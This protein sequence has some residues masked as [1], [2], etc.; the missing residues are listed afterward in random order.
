MRRLVTICLLALSATALLVGMPAASSAGAKK[1]S[2]PSITRVTPMRV[3]VGNLLT[4]RGRHFKAKRTANTVIFRASSGRTAFAKPRRASTRKLVVV[5]PAAVSRLLKV[6]GS[7]QRPTR[8]KLR[9][10]AGRFS[11]Y[12]PRRLS[13]VVTGFGDGDG[14]G[15]VG[16]GRSVG[17]GGGG[18]GVANSCAN[19][20]D[21]DDDLLENGLEAQIGTDPC[22]PDTD[23]DQ[24]TDGWEYWAAKDLNIKALPYPGERPFPNALDPSDG[25]APG[26][27]FSMIDFDGDGLTTL[28]EYRAWRSTGSSFDGAAAAPSSALG[29]SDGTKLS[30]PNDAPAAPALFDDPE[31]RDS[32]R[33]A[34]G[35]GLANW[36]ESAGGPSTN[37]WWKGWFGSKHFQPTVEPWKNKEYCGYRFGHFDQRPF[38]DFDLADGDV[39]GDGLL[40]GADDQD[41]DDV[42]NIVELYETKTDLD[43]NGQ[44]AF[45]GW[46]PGV[47]PTINFGG[48]TAPVN[49]MNPCA[50][51]PKSRTCQDFIPFN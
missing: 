4:I 19:D 28:E 46:G 47:V 2:K 1:A 31:W 48:V 38:A 36:L 51:N 11:S 6:A 14:R 24:M 7:R 21:H 41:S 37:N 43:G 49:A 13:P 15:P 9:V 27:R 17:G 39:D 10:L 8:L 3:S 35:D 22:L 20:S 45:C 5:V 50:P 32:E 33:D 18:G 26:A 40:D 34:D 16:G 25:G 44:P 42:I 30:R 29:Y 23:R 12:T